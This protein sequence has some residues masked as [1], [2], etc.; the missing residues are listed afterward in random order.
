MENFCCK[1]KFSINI[2]FGLARQSV[3]TTFKQIIN[4]NVDPLYCPPTPMNPAYCPSAILH[5]R[6]TATS[7]LRQLFIFLLFQGLVRLRDFLG[8][9]LRHRTGQRAER[10]GQDRLGGRLLRTEVH[11]SNCKSDGQQDGWRRS[12]NTPSSFIF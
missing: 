3:K 2:W 12:R 1:L 4:G 9:A 5:I 7:D 11:H 10:R 8:R 6:P